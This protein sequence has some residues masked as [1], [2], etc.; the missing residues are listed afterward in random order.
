MKPVA[1]LYSTREGHTQLIAEAIA[2]VLAGRGLRSSILDLGRQLVSADLDR[3]DAVVI[4]SPV[5]AGRFASEAIAFAK[6]HRLELE[7]MTNAFVSV[8][9]SEAG[10]ERADA[11]PEEHAQS[12]AQVKSVNERFFAQTGWIPARVENAAGALAYSHY[13]FVMR[14]IMQRIARKSGGSTDTSRDH[15][16]TDWAALDRFAATFAEDIFAAQ[17]RKERELQPS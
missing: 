3:F 12:V 9:L 13:N 4:A 14:F 10:V 5:H 15:D 8:T 11:T 6:K 17:A 16:Y 7:R 2:K 1:I